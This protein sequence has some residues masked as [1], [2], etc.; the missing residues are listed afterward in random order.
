MPKYIPR[1]FCFLKEYELTLISTSPT[2]V[3]FWLDFFL[4]VQ[5]N[6]IS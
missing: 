6:P 3:A 2:D 1:K 5:S 4:L